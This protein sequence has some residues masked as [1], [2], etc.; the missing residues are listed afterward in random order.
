M[1]FFIKLKIT[2]DL[3]VGDYVVFE[4]LQEGME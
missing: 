4:K 2:N 1:H 3:G